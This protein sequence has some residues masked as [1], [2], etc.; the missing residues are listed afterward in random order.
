[1]K[2][3]Y[4]ISGH[5]YGHAVRS[6]P[7]IRGLKD[8]GCTV[9][10]K[11]LC[12]PFLFRDGGKE[13][14]RVLPEEFD[15]GLV[16]TDNL[17]FDLEKTY[18]E[19]TALLDS[20]EE[21][22][23]KEKDFLL[24]NKVNGVVCDIPFLPL[25]AAFRA[26]L[27]SAAVGNFSWDWIYAHYAKKDE[28]WSFVVRAIRPY[29]RRAGLLLRLP[30]HG[31]MKAFPR[32]EDIPLVLRRS[33]MKKMEIRRLLDLPKD[34]KIGLVAFSHLSL[35]SR[36]LKEINA[37]SSR[38][39]FLIREPLNWEG[40]A[41]RK[42][43]G[44]GL[45]FIDLVRGADFVL[46]KP[47]YGIVSDCLAHKVPMVYC[48]RGD[49]PEYAILVKAIKTGLPHQYLSQKDLYEGRWEKVLAPFRPPLGGRLWRGNG[50]GVAAKKIVRWFVAF[51]REKDR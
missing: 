27:P 18:K 26:G 15:V 44:K 46:T 42:V 8:L 14:I 31:P 6:V 22:I 39:L 9:L 28:R 38:C 23:E 50:A 21:R 33:S 25:E 51:Y 17:R 16:Q 36:A 7:V 24:R 43:K 45:S 48:D 47:G 49:F 32:V 30:F 40:P 35:S 29:Y 19:V 11:T 41:F 34:R 13:G 20:A 5:G 2:I 4:Y 3:G 1:M 10:I 12:P 37:L